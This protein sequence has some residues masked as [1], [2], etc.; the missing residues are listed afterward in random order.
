M[1]DKKEGGILGLRLA[2]Q[3]IEI[4]G[5]RLVLVD[6]LKAVSLGGRGSCLQ[7]PPESC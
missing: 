1:K 4:K 7:L 2:S 5:T 6:G 3:V